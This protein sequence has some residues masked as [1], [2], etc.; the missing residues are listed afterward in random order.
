MNISKNFPY[1]AAVFLFCGLAFF[2]AFKSR[3]AIRLLTT[4]NIELNL[5]KQKVKKYNERIRLKL[6]MNSEYLEPVFLLDSNNDTVP[7]QELV[8]SPKL[9]FRFTEQFCSP[10]I[11]HALASLKLLGDSIGHNNILI[12]SD[13]E[14]SN[15]LK[16][17][18]KMNSISSPCYSYNRPFNFE[19]EGKSGSERLPYYMVLDQYLHVSFP[20][21]AEENNELN[22][23]YLNRIKLLF[24][25]KQ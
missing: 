10:C 23:I 12:I 13:A 25:R 18:I 21:F 15:L 3:N 17:F 20:F 5:Q 24:T 8:K 16:I 7:I 14:N 11:E 9:L 1:L 4:A 22:S 19:I 6:F 2:F